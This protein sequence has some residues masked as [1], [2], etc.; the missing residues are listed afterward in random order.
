MADVIHRAGTRFIERYRASLTWA[1]LK[2]LSAIARCR[3]AALGGH[4]DQCARCG[5]QAISYNSCRNRHCPKCQ[6]NTREKWLRAREQELLPVSYFHLVFS[7]PHALV[8]LIW[9]NKK[10]LFRLLFEASSATLLE[11]A[12]DP[13]RLGA[14]IGCLSILHTWGQTLQPHP[15]IH[16]VVPGGGLSP[17]HSRWTS[18]RSQFF[19]PVKVLSRV[20]RGKFVAGLKRAF[21]RKKLAFHGTCLPLS[22]EKAFAQF[23]RTLFRQDWVVY[24]KPPFG[25]PKHVL[26]YLARYTHRVAISNHRIVDVTDTLVAFHWKD[27]AHHNRRRVMTLS[28]EEFLRRFL[29]HVLPKGFLRIRYFGF[30][31]NRRRGQLLPL[32]RTLL[33]PSVP[34]PETS[35][36]PVTPSSEPA[37]WQC[38][39]CPGPMQI[40]ERLTA[41]Q[42]LSEECSQVYLIDSS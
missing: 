33:C 38:P 42:I 34:A 41:L 3:T 30:L 10:V 6:T 35:T 24:S 16:C 27:Y 11:V 37:I 8:P 1:Q 26:Q 28:H 23:L 25:G 31:A 4:R 20:F 29:L 39:R 7:V 40:L 17:D 32:C 18:S 21:R 19:L 36:P 2:V 13:K 5:Y 9:Q 15:H 12:A 22:N 14:E